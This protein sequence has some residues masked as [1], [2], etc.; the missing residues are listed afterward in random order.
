[1]QYLL[2]EEEMAA[3]RSE[4]E[5][6]RQIPVGGRDLIEGLG[7]VCKMVADTMIV[8]GATAHQSTH[9]LKRN[10]PYGCI[11]GDRSDKYGYCDRCPVQ[12]ICPL[13]KSWSK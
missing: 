8:T 4:R 6:L 7:N 9:S 12:G 13:P 1:M 11:H 5:A 3:I 2:S 10:S